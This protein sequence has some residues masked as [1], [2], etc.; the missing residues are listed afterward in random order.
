[1]WKETTSWH[2]NSLVAGFPLQERLQMFP[3]IQGADLAKRCVHNRLEWLGLPIAPDRPLYMCWLDIAAMVDDLSSG[4]DEGLG[5]AMYKLE[6]CLSL[7]PRTINAFAFLR[8]ACI[9]AISWDFSVNEF[10]MYLWVISIFSITLFA[11][12]A[13][14]TSVVNELVIIIYKSRHIIWMDEKEKR[15]G[16]RRLNSPWIIW[17]LYF[18]EAEYIHTVSTGLLNES[19]SLLDWPLKI[20]P[21]R[22]SLNGTHPDRRSRHGFECWWWREL[23]ECKQLIYSEQ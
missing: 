12:I 5:C 1:M 19:H 7:Y 14:L 10:A 23:K 22:L 11:H 3:A 20:Q 15:W 21:Y 17:N 9:L 6:P 13:L 16:S 2:V 18:R 4:W 8:A